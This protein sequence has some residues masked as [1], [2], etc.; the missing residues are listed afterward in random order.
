M[1]KLIILGNTTPYQMFGAVIVTECATLVLDGGLE[2]DAD[3]LFAVL[4]REGRGRVDA[5][6]FTHPHHDHLGAFMALQ[7]SH[8]ELSVGAIYHRFPSRETLRLC[9]AHKAHGGIERQM[10]E[11]IWDLFEGALKEKTHVLSLGETFS[12]DEVS[13]TVLRVMDP[14]Y[15][16]KKNFVNNSSAVFR[17]DTPRTRVLFLGDLGVQGGEDLMAALPAEELCADYTQMA[18]HGQKGVNRAFYEYVK[19][20]R[21]IWP[22][23]ER[24]W[25]N[26]GEGGPGTGKWDT[27][28]TRAWM[29]ELG[30][31]EHIIEKDGTQTV[32]I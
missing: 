22:T 28:E 24:I 16:T 23:P 5:W 1:T 32:L 29:R 2:E 21:C 26:V 18:H 8:P 3:E 17:L 27:A 7:R 13:L 15:D 4:K 6:F 30:V 9:P 20:R 10:W 12:F 25:D 14:T 11:D 31:T 19:P